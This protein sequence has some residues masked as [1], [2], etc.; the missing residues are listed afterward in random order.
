VS[1]LYANWASVYDYFY[2]DRAAEVAFWADLAGTHGRQVL[3]LMCGT[4]E[5]SLALARRGHSILGV[6]LSS[7]MLATARERLAAAADYPARRVSLALGDACAIP[8]PLILSWWGATAPSTTW[9]ATGRSPPC[10]SCA[11]RS[12][13]AAGW[14]WSCSIP[15]C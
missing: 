10:T 11:V 6:D 7:A 12:G 2:P 13:L 15:S 14:G 5:V 1:D 8:A 9:P 3:D 4:A